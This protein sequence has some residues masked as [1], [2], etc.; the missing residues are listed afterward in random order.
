MDYKKG[1]VPNM[2]DWH[3]WLALLILKK[4][5][6]NDRKWKKNKDEKAR[7]PNSAFGTLAQKEIPK[8]AF[9]PISVSLLPLLMLRFDVF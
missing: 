4:N 2:I 8:Q 7:A 5:E 3:S 1:R 9:L 6:E